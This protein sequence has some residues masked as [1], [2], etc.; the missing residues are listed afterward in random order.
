MEPLFRFLWA[1]IG[2][3]G[4]VVFTRDAPSAGETLKRLFPGWLE[5]RYE[6]ASALLVLLFGTSLA[7][8]YEPTDPMKAMF[9][10]LG[11]VSLLRQAIQ[12]ADRKKR[13]TAKI[14]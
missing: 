12:V 5:H 14:R 6:Q 1:F 9:A 7:Y 11:S 8:L 3:L 10:G 2:C 4:A 13:P